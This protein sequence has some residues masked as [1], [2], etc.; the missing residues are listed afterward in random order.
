MNGWLLDTNVLSRFAPSKE[1][2]PRV[3]SDFARWT[4]EHA[5]RLFLSTISIT[6]VQ[7]GIA[8]LQRTGATR[9]VH[10]VR[11]WLLQIVE[12]YGDRT[13][14]FDVKTALAAGDIVDRSTATGRNPGL[15][16]IFIAATAER[17]RLVILTEN[18]RHFDMLRL[19]VPIVNPGLQIPP[20]IG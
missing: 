2:Q 3:G 6:E 13:L 19:T 10:A 11:A 1:G 8:K 7:A 12:V 17:W 14:A 20:E 5:D 15:S 9:R 16:D 4:R 18:V